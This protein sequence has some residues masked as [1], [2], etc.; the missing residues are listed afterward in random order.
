MH[1]AERA[2]SQSKIKDFCQLSQRESQDGNNL[3]NHLQLKRGNAM[4]PEMLISLAKE[5]MN[6]AQGK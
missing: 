6:R 2:P 5:A 1:W 3:T 4:T